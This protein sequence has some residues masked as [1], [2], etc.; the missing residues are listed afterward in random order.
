[1]R[2]HIDQIQWWLKAEGEQQ[3]K[4]RTGR[5]V[6]DPITEKYSKNIQLYKPYDC[7]L[8]MAPCCHN[9]LSS[10]QGDRKPGSVIKTGNCDFLMQVTAD[11][12]HRNGTELSKGQR[13]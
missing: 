13:S 11:T 7:S 3:N 5:T 2:G 10:K 6:E 1:M 4:Y 8:K 12:L 9:E